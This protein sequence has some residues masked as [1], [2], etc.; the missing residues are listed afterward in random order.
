MNRE[1]EFFCAALE[2]TAG[3]GRAAFLA[4]AC[5]G[6][7]A[8]RA[9]LES[10]LRAAGE[11]GG[12]LDDAHAPV[13][14]A[15]GAR[16]G[17]YRLLEKLGEGGF[18]VV[19]RAEQDEPVRRTV[20]LKIIKLGMDTRAVVA[21]FEAE[22]QALAL[23][24]HSHIARVFDAGAT[25]AGRPYFVMELVRGVPITTFCNERRLRLRERLQVFLQVCR[26]VHH[27]H[28]KGVIHRDLKPTNIIITLAEN[29]PVAKVIDFGIA[30]ATHEPLTEKTLVTRLHAFMGTPAYMSPEQVGLGDADVD[31]RSDIYSL[32]ALLYEVLAD[33][34]PLATSALLASGYA[35]VQQAIHRIEPP[36]PSA[37]VAALKPEAKAAAAARRSVSPARLIAELDGDLDRI[38][39]KCLEKDRTRRY[40]TM[41]DFAQDITRFLRD[42]PVLARPATIGY[43]FRKFVR[44]HQRSV[45]AGAVAIL[46][47]VGFGAYHTRRL[48]IERD[49]AQLEA[50]KR[51]KVSEIVTGLLTSADPFRT[52]TGAGPGPA[53]V[54]DASA[55]RVRREFADEPDVRSEILGTIGRVYLRL[56]QH[57]KAQPLLEEALAAGRATGRPDEQFAQTLSDLGVLLRERGDY[58]P[59]IARFEEALALRRRLL[60]NETND[61]AITLVELGRAQSEI[62][63]IDLAEPL[64]REA[65]AI[66]ERVLGE[67]DRETATSLGDL[68][69]VLWQKGDLAAAAPFLQQ[70]LATHRQLLGAAHPNVGS[71]LA[72]FAALKLDQSDLASADSLLRESLAIMR[73]SLG[74]RHWRTAN[75][76]GS[77]ATVWRLE[78]RRAEAAAAL[79]GAIG[80]A[81]EA[82]GEGGPVVASLRV[83]RARVHLELGEFSA[84]EALLRDALRVQQPRYGAGSWRTATTKSLLGGA[85]LGLGRREEAEPFLLEAS[86]V[87]KDLPGPQGRETTATRERLAELAR[88]RHPTH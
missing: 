29:R 68:G 77:L 17:R 4:D 26:A 62:D 35:A 65:L 87:L 48:A 49:R 63:R 81:R 45:A 83:E 3:A 54:L 31:T 56:G 46:L 55:A 72:N 70:S 53:G 52:P 88:L 50:E 59:A 16:I 34:P 7:Q 15:A 38:V 10:L 28:Q 47:L 5:A 6:D 9:R 85:L 75:V 57:D 42:E 8:F 69:V 27:A 32:G 76:M 33:S 79:D 24:D 20:A 1:Q 36:P 61:V 44:R 74:P 40:E 30:K 37:R 13:R 64:F 21:R 25:E 66:R 60:G 18:G 71:A 11:A 2:R 23:M 78:G 82:L 14:E 12:F 43:R 51:A 86:R 80:I 22:R 39:L 73:G 58:P 19:Y 41:E 67:L 84:A